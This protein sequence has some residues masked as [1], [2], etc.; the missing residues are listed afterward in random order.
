MSECCTFSSILHMTA[1]G[2]ERYVGVCFPLRARLLVTRGRVRVLIGALWG[3][4]VLSAGPVLGLVGAEPVEGNL[5]ECRVT[6][7]AESSGLMVAMLWLS[8]L[9]FIIPLTTLT[10]L[11]T[12]IARRLRQRR[13]IHRD[14]T[15]RQTLRMMGKHTR[16]KG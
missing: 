9:Y 5:T 4:A 7:W 14:H 11:Y 1:L 8:N 15:H 16:V 12:L 10:L 2:A 3:V 6:Q 13:H